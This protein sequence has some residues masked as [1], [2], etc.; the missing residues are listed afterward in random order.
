MVA[1]GGLLG[2]QHPQDLGVFPALRGGVGD[3]LRRGAADIWQPQPAEQPLELVG[4]RRRGGGADGHRPNPS[5]ARVEPAASLSA[6]GEHDHLTAG[7]LLVGE[8]RREVPVGEP[9]RTGAGLKA[10]LT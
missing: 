3:H 4:Q 1:A 9:A 2:E 8:D 7:A 5:H 6:G 10:R